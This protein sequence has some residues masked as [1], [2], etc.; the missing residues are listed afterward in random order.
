[1]N[2]PIKTYDQWKTESPDDYAFKC[3][4]FEM[5]DDIPFDEDF[6]AFPLEAEPKVILTCNGAEKYL[7]DIKILEM[8]TDFEEFDIVVFSCSICRESHESEVIIR[9]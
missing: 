5:E 4:F 6:T 2:L 9:I 3:D 7:N 1:M 8:K